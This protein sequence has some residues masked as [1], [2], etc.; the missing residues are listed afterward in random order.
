VNAQDTSRCGDGCTEALERLEAYLDGA[1][2]EDDLED[3]K[4]HLAACYPCTD[5]ASFEE[6]LRA[7]IRER[8]VE[9]APP[10]LVARIRAQLSGSTSGEH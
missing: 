10:A 3:I 8:C 4:Q 2:P 1:L 7:V 6:Q 9:S 5:R